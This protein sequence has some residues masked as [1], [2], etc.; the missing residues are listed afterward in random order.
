MTLRHFKIFCTV[1]DMR[2]ITGAAE[3]LNMTQPSVSLAIKELESFYNVKLFE[4]MNRTIYITEAGETL[5]Q[6]ASNVIN[7]MD[8]SVDVMRNEQL[9]GRCR[10]GVNVTFAETNLAQI[11]KRIEDKNSN[12]QLKIIINNTDV[13][14]KM[15]FNNEIDIAIVDKFSDLRN[16]KMHLLYAEK[17]VV[18]CA[19]SQQKKSMRI[20]ELAK[21]NLL[22]RNKGSANRNSVDAAFRAAGHE[23]VAKVE[24][25]SSLALLRMAANGIGYTILPRKTVSEDIKN[26]ALAEVEITDG[27][28]ERHYYLTYHESKFVTK[29]MKCVIEA[30]KA[31]TEA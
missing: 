22:L 23:V 6:Y 2:S 15:L 29:S 21:E 20:G 11:I 3:K 31:C 1:C 27:C 30:I 13:I 24:S 8:E 9:T 16:R 25:V 19:P 28:F 4:R 12:L 17:M 5:L 7:Q 18:V 14:E 10:I 26:G